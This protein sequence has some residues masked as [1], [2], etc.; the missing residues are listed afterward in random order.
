M[1]KKKASMINLGFN[2]ANAMFAIVNGLV[3]V[4]MYLNY[5]SISTYGSYLS[6]GNVVTMLGLLE[7]GMSMVLTQKLAGCYARKDLKVFSN[8]MG[9]GL[10]ISLILTILLILIGLLFAP[11]IP[12]WVKADD[13]E[14]RRIGYAFFLSALAAGL[15][16][17]FSNLSA[18]F[19]ATLKVQ[20]SG[21]ANLIGIILGL[22]S[23]FLG[24]KMGLG[25]VAIPLGALV[26]SFVG[27][28]ILCIALLRMIKKEHFPVVKFEKKNCGDII[29]LSLPVFGGNIAKSIVTN[30]QL[31]IITSFINPAASA[32]FFITGRIYLVCDSFLAPIGSSIFSSISHDIGENN[33]EKAKYNIS[34]VFMLFTTFSAFILTLSFAINASFISALLGKDKFGSITLSALLCTSML[35]YTRNNFLSM[36]LFALGIFGKT[37]LYDLIGALLKII[38]ILS[39]IKIIG[40]L[41]IPIAEIAASL[42]VSGYFLHKLIIKKLKMTSKEIMGFAFNGGYIF[43]LTFCAALLWNIYIPIAHNWK[44][45]IEQ[46]IL[47]S[48]INGVLIFLFSKGIRI[49]AAHLFNRLK[50]VKV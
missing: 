10:L 1:S 7:G 20:V 45:F 3:F 48:A 25:V 44:S 26:K 32:I 40:Y 6:S 2:Y 24:L 28:F 33:L 15:S 9:S 14:F 18:V 43:I 19:Q 13:N 47:I 21:A 41:I 30:S 37:V 34:Y 36:N 17:S 38:L 46:A 49:T 42:F 29:K 50:N 16:I 8:I 31:I 27:I 22:L 5:F 11:F 35:F 12:A 4:P 39:L 23:T